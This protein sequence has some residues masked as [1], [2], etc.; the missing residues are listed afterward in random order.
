MLHFFFTPLFT[1]PNSHT[2][3]FRL[4]DDCRFFIYSIGWIFYNISLRPSLNMSPYYTLTYLLNR[5][6]II[7][8]KLF[9]TAYFT[10]IQHSGTLLRIIISSIR[11]SES[12]LCV[13]MSSFFLLFL[14][15]VIED[16]GA[17]FSLFCSFIF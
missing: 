5:F 16:V 15:Y 12:L 9:S 14:Y 4:I 11:S 2:F 8:L 3:I 17:V 6:F 1:I 13:N 7:F 10:A